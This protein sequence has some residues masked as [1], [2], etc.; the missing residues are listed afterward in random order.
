ML[1][2]LEELHGVEKALKDHAR[3]QSTPAQNFTGTACVPSL[4]QKLQS[5]EG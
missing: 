2:G 1:S 5:L 4:A 3:A